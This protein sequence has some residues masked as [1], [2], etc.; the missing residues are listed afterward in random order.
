MKLLEGERKSRNRNKE[1]TEMTVEEVERQI[2][3]LKNRK[4]PRK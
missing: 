1:E 2:K 3:K 4:A